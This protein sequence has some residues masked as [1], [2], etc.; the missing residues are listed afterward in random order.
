[1]RSMTF[2]WKGNPPFQ[3]PVGIATTHIRPLTNNDIGNAFPAPFGRP[4][5]IKHWRRGVQPVA[6]STT[7]LPPDILYNTDRSTYGSSASLGGGEPGWQARAPGAVRIPSKSVDDACTNCNGHPMVSGFYP[8]ASKSEVPDPNVTPAELPD[9]Y[10]LTVPDP[11][12][13]YSAERHAKKRVL[14]PISI[15]KKTYYQTNQLRRYN[16]CH[17]FAQRQFNFARG[18]VGAGDAYYVA[19]CVPN[20]SKS[21]G[22]VYYK[23]NNTKYAQ[24]GAVSSSTRTMTLSAHTH[25]RAL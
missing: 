9:D 10:S 19:Q 23:P 14:A 17:T 13:G 24:Q 3:N 8:I 11:W 16:Q 22:R 21:C 15:V 12:V 6:T 7:A 2:T 18:P 25:A 4:R 1:M 20:Q 5:P